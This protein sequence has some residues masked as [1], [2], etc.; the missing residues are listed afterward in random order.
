MKRIRNGVVAIDRVTTAPNKDA[1]SGAIKRALAAWANRTKPNSPA[2]LRSRP[3]RMLRGHECLNSRLSKLSRPALMTITAA[4][5]PST[6][7]G[8]SAI[9]WMSSSI[10]TE[11]KN[12]PRRIERNGSTS[13][14]SSWR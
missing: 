10:P 7:S 14:S 11:R 3:S 5:I 8:R 4:A 9:R 12:S 13:L 1:A 6:N 2:W